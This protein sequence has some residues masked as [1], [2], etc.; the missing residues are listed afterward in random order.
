VLLL[1]PERCREQNALHLDGRQTPET[2]LAVLYKAICDAR[3]DHTHVSLE[4]MDALSPDWSGLDPARS[5]ADFVAEG[6]ES[7]AATNSPDWAGWKARLRAN[8]SKPPDA[9]PPAAARWRCTAPAGK[10]PVRLS[11]RFLTIVARE[12]GRWSTAPELFL[13]TLCSMQYGFRLATP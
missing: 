2:A 7:F 9:L 6:V 11:A 8:R 10:A 3:Q 13:P 4:P 12:A 1:S 5:A